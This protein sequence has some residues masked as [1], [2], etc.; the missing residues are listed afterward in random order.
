MALLFSPFA[1]WLT[2]DTEAA[3][4][5]TDCSAIYLSSNSAAAA[6]EADDDIDA[7]DADAGNY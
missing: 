7:V 3:G 5:V 2:I 4:A 1:C 6:A